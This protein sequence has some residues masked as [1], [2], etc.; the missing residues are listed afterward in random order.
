MISLLMCCKTKQFDYSKA[1]EIA[2]Q[3]TET[4]HTA[5]KQE[6]AAVTRIDSIVID[7]L[8]QEPLMIQDTAGERF[9]NNKTILQKSSSITKLNKVKLYGVEINTSQRYSRDTVISTTNLS[10]VKK[11]PMKGNGSKVKKSTKAGKEHIVIIVLIFAIVTAGF[12]C[13]KIAVQ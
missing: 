9:S 13:W 12:V 11:N 1:Y 6:I 2:R 4:Q 3:E 8:F 10:Q 7:N 5:T